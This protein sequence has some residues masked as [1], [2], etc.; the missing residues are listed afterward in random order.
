MLRKVVD[1]NYLTNP[2]LRTY[3]KASD[4][5]YALLTD[6][7]GI[8]AYKE[9]TGENIFNSIEIL[10]EFP[11]QVQ[12]LIN[13]IVACGI[14]PSKKAGLEWLIDKDQ[15][16][17][18]DNFCLS[19]KTKYGNQELKKQIE[20]N[21]EQAQYQMARVALDSKNFLQGMIELEKEYTSKVIKDL[22]VS[23]KWNNEIKKNAWEQS[24]KMAQIMFT[25][26]PS[27]YRLPRK[28]ELERTF[29]F[30]NCLCAQS[31]FINW[32]IQGSHAK[33]K[34]D[35]IKNDIIDINFA[36]FA[37]YFDGILT[38]D[39]KLINTYNSAK[40]ILDSRIQHD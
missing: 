10:S 7:N 40:D 3:L 31:Y 4:Q 2:E 32:I 18:F 33:L 38:S 21:Q 16:N 19:L 39:K 34:E 28:D 30:K 27:T 36:A 8:E 5:N 14:I 20:M 17:G 6:Y 35:N 25:S 26:H 1:S 15:T 24:K 37:L 9:D 13:T 11:N 23:K 12:I 22:R 29:I